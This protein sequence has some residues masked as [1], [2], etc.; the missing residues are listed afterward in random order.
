[1]PGR[2][3]WRVRRPATDDDGA[4]EEVEGPLERPVGP[5]EHGWAQ[6]EERHALARDVGRL[7]RQELRG[8]RRH[9]HGY[10]VAVGDVEELDDLL[11]LE[12]DALH[13][14]LVRV[15][16]KERLLHRA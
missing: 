8:R 10:A 3:T 15:V 12:V 1:M 16:T 14:D 7:V 11:L 5:R 2:P 6:L 4:D 13:D 9:P